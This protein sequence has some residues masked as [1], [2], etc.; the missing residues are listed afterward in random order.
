MFLNCLNFSFVKT[1]S[2][3]MFFEPFKNVQSVKTCIET[4]FLSLM[5]LF[6]F[7]SWFRWDGRGWKLHWE[8]RTRKIFWAV[9]CSR[10]ISLV[11]FS[12][13][14]VSFKFFI[15]YLSYMSY[16]TILLV[17]KNLLFQVDLMKTGHS[18][19]ST[20]Q[21]P[22]PSTESPMSW[23]QRWLQRQVE[24][25]MCSDTRTL[26]ISCPQWYRCWLCYKRKPSAFQLQI[27]RRQNKRKCVNDL[28]FDI[29]V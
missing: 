29:T 6:C 2:R 11:L 28:M 21:W 18:L 14:T 15:F 5:F 25:P 1:F 3:R 4:M 9:L 24:Q 13:F 10:Y 19:V 8:V 16:I 23:Q 7:I 22:R 20:W 17:S 26:I 27:R 12:F